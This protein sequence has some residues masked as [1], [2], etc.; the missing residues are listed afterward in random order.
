MAFVKSKNWKEEI[1]G[2]C[3]CLVN[4]PERIEDPCPT[5]PEYKC[6][7]QGL[8]KL[9]VQKEAPGKKEFMT[10]LLFAGCFIRKQLIA[11][12]V[13]VFRMKPNA[14]ARQI[15]LTVKELEKKGR[16]VTKDDSNNYVVY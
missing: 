16:K 5:T 8:R 12:M 9:L 11:A 2:Y 14:A 1:K 7:V 10:S 4:F 3:Y 6:P 13:D 15:V